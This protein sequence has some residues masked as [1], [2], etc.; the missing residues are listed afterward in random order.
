MAH[1]LVC[2]YRVLDSLAK[3]FK[4]AEKALKVQYLL[5][6]NTTSRGAPR[7]SEIF[8]QLESTVIIIYRKGKQQQ[9]QRHPT[10]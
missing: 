6:S 8:E 3:E 5:E 7:L 2:V 1:L 9:Q 4:R 10:V